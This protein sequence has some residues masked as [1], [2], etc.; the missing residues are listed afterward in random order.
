M[1]EQTPAEKLNDEIRKLAIAYRAETAIEITS[2]SVDWLWTSTFEDT[3]ASI[4]GAIE[5]D[6]RNISR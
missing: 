5:I 2:I 1:S 4:P 3:R 6:Q